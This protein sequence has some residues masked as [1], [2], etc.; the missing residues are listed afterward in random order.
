MFEPALR[1]ID[2]NFKGS[3]LSQLYYT[4]SDGTTGI[5]T[6]NYNS[7]NAIGIFYQFI[8]H[9]VQVGAGNVSFL[10]ERNV[11]L[12]SFAITSPDVWQPIPMVRKNTLMKVIASVPTFIFT[13]CY[14]YIYF[15]TKEVK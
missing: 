4:V 3:L 7:Q 1:Y 9:P 13:V 12:I 11:P 10:V 15:P 5:A 6:A 8:Y 14:Q 2:Q